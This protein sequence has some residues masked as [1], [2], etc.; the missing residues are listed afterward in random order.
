MPVSVFGSCLHDESSECW[1]PQATEL[2][3]TNLVGESIMALLSYL[4]GYALLGARG[5]LL[6]V[7]MDDMSVTLQEEYFPLERLPVSS[8]GSVQILQ[9]GNVL[10]GSGANPWQVQ[11]MLT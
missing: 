7:N 11:S 5:L 3:W 6:D 9:D 4:P 2:R 1:I 10:M 8:Q